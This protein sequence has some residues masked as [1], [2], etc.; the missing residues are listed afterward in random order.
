[1]ELRDENVRY[2]VLKGCD[3]E[4]PPYSKQSGGP[5]PLTDLSVDFSEFSSGSFWCCDISFGATV[6]S[7]L[8]KT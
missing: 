4:T 7:L 3:E 5:Y 2:L 6:K 1:M 8:F